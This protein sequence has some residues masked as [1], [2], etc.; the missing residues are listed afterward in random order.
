M[1]RKLFCLFVC[2]TMVFVLVGCN[3]SN[4]EKS[5]ANVGGEM[6]TADENKNEVW[7]V[8][9]EAKSKIKEE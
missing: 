8:V 4:E 6:E 3:S 9:Y 7:P 1:K 2:F 5:N